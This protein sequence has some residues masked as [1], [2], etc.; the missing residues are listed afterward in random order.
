LKQHGCDFETHGGGEGV[1]GVEEGGR[2]GERGTEDEGKISQREVAI[3]DLKHG[4]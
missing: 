3:Q 2:K 4:E 1:E